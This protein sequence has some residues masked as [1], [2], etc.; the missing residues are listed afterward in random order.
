MQVKK[1]TPADSLSL[2]GIDASCAIEA[3]DP[4]AV[5][6]VFDADA[7]AGTW[8][9]DEL[10]VAKIDPYMR[11]GAPHGIEKHQI[12]GF[13]FVTSNDFPGFTHFSGAA[14][15]DKAQTLAKYMADE[16]RA[17]ESGFRRTA[18][19]SISYA[20]QV[21]GLVDCILCRGGRPIDKRYG[22]RRRHNDSFVGVGKR[23]K[24]N[25]GED[26]YPREK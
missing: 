4:V 13:Q 21:Q 2:L 9:M 16:A 14:R 5:A 10:V 11:K 15:K 25:C 7:A 3:F 12:A 19:T 1:K 18:A 22:R 6:K 23:D 17:I 24:N 8:R 26:K 20:Q